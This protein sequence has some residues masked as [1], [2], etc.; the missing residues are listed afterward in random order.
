MRLVGWEICLSGRQHAGVGPVW[1]YRGCV[2]V[3]GVWCVCFCVCVCVNNNS[4]DTTPHTLQGQETN[5]YG[6]TNSGQT[7]S[8]SRR[9]VNMC[10]V[11]FGNI[12]NVIR[13]SWLVIQIVDQTGSKVV[14]GVRWCRDA[15]A[16]FVEEP[17]LLELWVASKLTGIGYG[18][19]LA[20][21]LFTWL[22]V[23]AVYCL[24]L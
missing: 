22:L 2:Y 19:M 9:H 11:L 24:C 3:C 1:W 21:Y 7:C 12:G 17:R 15:W 13:V 5:M 4:T 10:L 8:L 6:S 18:D 14:L 23:C 16:K 20:D